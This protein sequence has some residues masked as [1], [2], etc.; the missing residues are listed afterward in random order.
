[1][2]NLTNCPQCPKHCPVEALSC[3]RGRAYFGQSIEAQPQE[4]HDDHHH[5]EHGH[6][7]KPN[8]DSLEGLLRFFGHALHHGSVEDDAFTA[9]SM[10]EQEQLKGLLKKLAD[11]WNH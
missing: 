7:G 10:D 9:L 5:G 1:M 11:S 3:G 8:L 2:D 4:V 6:H